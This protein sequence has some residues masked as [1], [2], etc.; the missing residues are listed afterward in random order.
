MQAILL[1][2]V[3]LQKIEKLFGKYMTFDN[4]RLNEFIDCFDVGNTLDAE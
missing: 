1:C 3:N 2:N 4:M